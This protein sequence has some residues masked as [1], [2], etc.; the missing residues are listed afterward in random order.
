M[1][2]IDIN[3]AIT[4]AF[5][6]VFFLILWKCHKNFV[7]NINERKRVIQQLNDELKAYTP[8]TIESSFEQL[9][10]QM[11]ESEVVSLQWN[12][13]ERS[14]FKATSDEG[15]KVFSTIDAEEYFN[16]KTMTEGSGIGFWQNLAGIFTGVGLLG[17][18]VGITIGLM[19]MDVSSNS[20]L[21]QGIRGLLGGTQT[22]F[23]TS[24]LGVASGL[25]Y[26]YWYN[27]HFIKKYKIE[28]SKFASCFNAL[29]PRKKIEDLLFEN[30][31]ESR[32]QTEQIKSLSTDLSMALSEVFNADFKPLFE[33]ILKVLEK[34]NS[35]GADKIGEIINE[36]SA[37]ELT[38]FVGSL[39]TMQ[40]NMQGIME[41]SVKLSKDNNETIKKTVQEL[42]TSLQ[43]STT[44]TLEA[45]QN[46]M[47]DLTEHMKNLFADLNNQISNTM[48][49]YKTAGDNVNQD[50]KSSLMEVT[51]MYKMMSEQIQDSTTFTQKEFLANTQQLHEILEKII[52]NMDTDITTHQSVM[53]QISEDIHATLQSS[54]E[55]VKH[56]GD[57]ADKFN[58]AAGPIQ[59]VADTMGN[60]MSKVIEASNRFQ[61]NVEDNTNKL[62]DTANKNMQNT[63]QTLQSLQEIQS[64][65]RAYENNFKDMSG[66]LEKTFR[67]VNKGI[68]D[69]NNA[70]NTGLSDAL[71]KYDESIS[72]TLSMLQT[73][74]DELNDTVDEIR[75]KTGKR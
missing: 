30:V 39:Q 62:N 13:Y 7:A 55:L 49:N 21:Q 69:Y 37:N 67:Q 44:S 58:K 1:N 59:D 52:Q 29:F 61:R 66:E 42:V 4:I 24:V 14:L 72:R 34:I 74:L 33:D 11:N 10:N 25:V 5:V 17:T 22:A 50:F 18:F 12:Q 9:K 41:E 48:N 75:D 64:A 57:T 40:D 60:Q 53:K 19:Y 65:W 23:I 26:N 73:L 54:R 56:A 3:W 15:V 31:V 45:Q 68:I 38:K 51:K 6:W 27:V 28:I 35:T 2:N 32:E 46:K 63:V 36:G 70:T 71:N 20:G 47:I 8:L 16:I 43:Q